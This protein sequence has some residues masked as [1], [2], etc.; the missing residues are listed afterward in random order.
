M[1]LALKSEA[2]AYRFTGDPA[3]VQSTFDRLDMIYQYHG[4]ASGSSEYSS[5]TV[6]SIY[7]PVPISLCTG[8]FSA[9]EHLAGLGPSRGW[10]HAVTC[11]AGILDVL[12]ELNCAP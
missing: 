1:R 9:D 3:D 6:K 11:V 7:K 12:A 8:T 5:P 4:R 10:V 2:L